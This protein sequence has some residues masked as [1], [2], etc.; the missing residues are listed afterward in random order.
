MQEPF[1]HVLE[2]TR[3]LCK[4]NPYNADACELHQDIMEL[5]SKTNEDIDYK[6]KHGKHNYQEESLLAA[7]AL[8]KF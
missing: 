1:Y 5:P 6:E 2:N 4:D 8:N 7:Q 3:P